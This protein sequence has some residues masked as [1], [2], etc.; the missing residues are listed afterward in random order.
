M[1]TSKHGRGPS[2]FAGRGERVRDHAAHACAAHERKK[3]VL[4]ARPESS[5]SP[6]HIAR[7]RMTSND[8]TPFPRARKGRIART[9]THE[10]APRV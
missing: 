7:A 1:L 5:V 3:S 4:D 9:E 10:D 8:R 6:V 2:A